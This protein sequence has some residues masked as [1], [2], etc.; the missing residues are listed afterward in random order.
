MKNFA[1]LLQEPGRGAGSGLSNLMLKL[2][3]ARSIAE[4][5]NRCCRAKRMRIAPM[6]PGQVRL[7]EK[8]CVTLIVPTQA[9]SYQLRNLLPTLSGAI[10]RATGFAPGAV[11]VAVNPGLVSGDDEPA[12]AGEPR[13]PNPEAARLIAEKAKRLPEGSRLKVTLENLADSLDG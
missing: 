1:S 3:L 12:P 8:G 13:R 9:Q 11:R 10:A 7:D 5:V 2:R 4:E 6:G